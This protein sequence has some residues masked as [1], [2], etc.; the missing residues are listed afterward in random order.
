[1]TNVQDN[2]F[3]TTVQQP[4]SSVSKTRIWRYDR[5]CSPASYTANQLLS[6]ALTP[7]I[8]AGVN[9]TDC[10]DLHRGP[11]DSTNGRDYTRYFVQPNLAFGHKLMGFLAGKLDGQREIY[12]S[13]TI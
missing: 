2:A 3:F 5:I 4:V 8:R 11:R 13:S 7:P 12:L 10:R 1:M 9:F 6:K